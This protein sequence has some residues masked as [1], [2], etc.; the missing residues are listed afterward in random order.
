[1]NRGQAHLQQYCVAP[2]LT[3]VK[4]LSTWRLWAAHV[5]SALR[6]QA[7]KPQLVCELALP[8]CKRVP[9]IACGLLMT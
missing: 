5:L 2:A 1:M 7:C 9:L 8:P 6:R 3:R 4:R